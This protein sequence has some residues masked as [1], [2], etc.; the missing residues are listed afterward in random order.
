[1]SACIPALAVPGSCA[2][3]C[4]V[5]AR[6]ARVAHAPVLPA[7][8]PRVMILPRLIYVPRT[9]RA[10][11]AG[12]RRYWG[13]GTAGD[14]FDPSSG[15]IPLARVANKNAPG[16]HGGYMQ[17]DNVYAKSYRRGP[18]GIHATTLPCEPEGGIC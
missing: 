7:R 10:C 14:L 8:L 1:M 13:A 15:S 5:C 12:G 17:T 6:E 4:L 2:R 3:V 9:M 11:M 18:A 16:G